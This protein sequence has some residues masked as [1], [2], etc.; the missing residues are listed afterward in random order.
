MLTFRIALLSTVAGLAYAILRYHDAF[1]GVYPTDQLP[2]Y[3]FNKALSV[4][5]LVMIVLAVGARALSRLPGRFTAGLLHERRAIGLTG[6]GLSLVHSAMSLAM[7]TPSY[8]CKLYQDN[9]RMNL[10]GELSMLAG[11]IALALLVCQGRLRAASETDDRRVLRRLGLSVLTL[12]AIHLLAMGWRG[13][14]DVQHWPGNMPPITLISFVI[15]L[16]GLSL[17][18]IS[19]G[20]RN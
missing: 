7:L 15:A 17:V 13:W 20:R 3:V 1:F 14:L 8:Y 10:E 4:T 5:A 2:L 11:L 9:G 18:L 6:L 19:P 16:V 12:V